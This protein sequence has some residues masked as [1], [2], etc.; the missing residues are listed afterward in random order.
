[1]RAKIALITTT[2]ASA[3]GPMPDYGDVRYSPCPTVAKY[4]RSNSKR[5]CPF[6]PC[7]VVP[8]SRTHHPIERLNLAESPTDRYLDEEAPSVVSSSKAANVRLGPRAYFEHVDGSPLG[9]LDA[10]AT[11]Q[12]MLA[13]SSD[14]QRGHRGPCHAR[15]RPAKTAPGVWPGARYYW[16]AIA[17]Y[18]AGVTGPIANVSVCIAIYFR[19]SRLEAGP[20]GMPIFFAAASI[21][22]SCAGVVTGSIAR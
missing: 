5:L 22:A 6:S 1:M 15:I 20:V 14:R 18:C 12:A 10:L 3:S 16:P 7:S 2:L 19:N 17:R 9:L 11:P 8:I 4:L 13:G 21:A